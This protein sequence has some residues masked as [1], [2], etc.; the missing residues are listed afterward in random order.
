MHLHRV[1]PFGIVH[2]IEMGGITN[3]YW[4]EGVR[5]RQVIII[6]ESSVVWSLISL[7]SSFALDFFF[8]WIIGLFIWWRGTSKLSS[9]RIFKL[10]L[11]LV[12]ISLKLVLRE[13]RGELLH[14]WALWSAGDG[15]GLS[16]GCIALG[17]TGLQIFPSFD[18][19]SPSG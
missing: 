15:R 5:G 6:K 12:N 7:P 3:G 14:T 4:G 13:L 16:T 9:L 10:L 19:T 1:S 11:E 17:W 8:G 2:P 18:I